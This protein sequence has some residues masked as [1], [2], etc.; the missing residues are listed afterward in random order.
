MAQKR[1]AFKAPPSPPAGF[2]PDDFPGSFRT[3]FAVLARSRLRPAALRCIYFAARHF[4][5]FQYKSSLFPGKVP[6]SWSDHPLDESVPFDPLRVKIYLSFVPF[7]VR[8][9]GFLLIRRKREDLALDFINAIAALYLD[10]SS[11]YRKNLSTTRRPFYIKNPSFLLIHITDPH[12]MCIPSLHV[13][14]VIR[15]YTRM[16]EYAEALETENAAYCSAV[17]RHALAITEAVLLVKQHG[18]NCIAAALFAMS[19]LDRN[20]PRGEAERFTAALFA[21]GFENGA[22]LRKHILALYGEFL[23]AYT[24]SPSDGWAAPLLAFL[25]KLPQKRKA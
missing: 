22:A 13:M 17:F 3:V 4:F 25:E 5:G 14:I 2:I 11:V 21:S 9:T 6:V 19:A 15:C 8:I 18:V 16:R 23:D 7:W 20:F 1:S 10:A 24:R 12:L